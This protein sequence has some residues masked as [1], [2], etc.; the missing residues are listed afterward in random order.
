MKRMQIVGPNCGWDKDGYFHCECGKCR[1]LDAEISEY[2]G[3][4]GNY[5]CNG[6]YDADHK[7]DDKPSF[8]GSL[9]RRR[10][11]H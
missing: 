10:S 2:S 3:D 7:I 1:P 9:F 6:T 8:F 5:R 11:F 4:S